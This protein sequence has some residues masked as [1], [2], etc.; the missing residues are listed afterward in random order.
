[1]GSGIITTLQNEKF[2]FNDA[3][4]YKFLYVERTTLM[5]EVNI[6]IR[7]ER[8]PYRNVDFSKSQY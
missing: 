3:G 1:M 6:Q 2:V 4:I 5:P 7:M 8:F